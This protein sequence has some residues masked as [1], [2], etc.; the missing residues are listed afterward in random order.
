MILSILVLNVGNVIVT[1]AKRLVIA[2]PLHY[3]SSL[4]EVHY[5]L[6]IGFQQEVIHLESPRF[7]QFLEQLL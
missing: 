7:K 2:T 1:Y 4:C 5:R 3:A 6:R